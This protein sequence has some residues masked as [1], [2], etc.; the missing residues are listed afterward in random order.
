M[1]GQRVLQRE[2]SEC[3]EH[4]AAN[5]QRLGGV[6]NDE[7]DQMLTLM[8]NVILQGQDLHNID[9]RKVATWPASPAASRPWLR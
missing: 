4:L 3:L 7:I 1:G 5:I 9:T 2:L 8:A 6:G